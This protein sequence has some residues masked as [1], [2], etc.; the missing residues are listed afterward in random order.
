[1]ALAAACSRVCVLCRRRLHTKQAHSVNLSVEHDKP[2]APSAHYPRFQWTH[3]PGSGELQCGSPGYSTFFCSKRAPSVSTRHK[4]QGTTHK[5]SNGTQ[6]RGSSTKSL[7]VLHFRSSHAQQ[8]QRPAAPGS[9]SLL[10]IPLSLHGI[11]GP[12]AAGPCWAWQWPAVAGSGLA[13]RPGSVISGPSTSPP[14]TTEDRGPRQEDSET[15]RD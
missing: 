4:A 12:W 7:V 10:L 13:G 11:C 3:R 5:V 1:M 6:H 8:H 15:E 9:P 14:S 2:Q